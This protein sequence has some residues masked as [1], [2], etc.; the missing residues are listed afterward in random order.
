MHNE[1]T[2]RY[3]RVKAVAERFDVSPSTIYRAIETGE[4]AAVKIGGS[5]RVPA[6]AVHAFETAATG[7]V[8]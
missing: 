5:L 1:A 6:E 8:A 2:P 4:L 3:F 7:E